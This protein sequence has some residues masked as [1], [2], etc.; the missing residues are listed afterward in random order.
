MLNLLR[1]MTKFQDEITPKIT[2]FSGEMQDLIT[3]RFLPSHS[4]SQVIR[5]HFPR[6]D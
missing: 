4:F 6:F 5:D 2:F 3:R 1:E